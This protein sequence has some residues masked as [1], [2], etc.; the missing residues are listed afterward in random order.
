[1]ALIKHHADDCACRHHDGRFYA[2]VPGLRTG[3]GG[4]RSQNHQ[5]GCIRNVPDAVNGHIRRAEAAECVTRSE[6]EQTDTVAGYRMDAYAVQA[7]A[8]L[9]RRTYALCGIAAAGEDYAYW[10]RC[11]RRVYP[12]RAV[13]IAEVKRRESAVS[14]GLYTVRNGNRSG[15]RCLVPEESH[16]MAEDAAYMMNF[17]T[18]DILIAVRFKVSDCTGMTSATTLAEFIAALQDYQAARRVQ[19]PL[20]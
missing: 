12:N 13:G 7:C 8:L 10:I 11:N 9:H 20:T 16:R 4:D 17:P 15:F 14:G 2:A 3:V 18:E 5:P 1:M 19:R 6:R